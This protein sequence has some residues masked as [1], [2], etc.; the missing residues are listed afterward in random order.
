MKK[1]LG[2]AV[3]LGLVAGMASSALAEDILSIGGDARWRGVYMNNTT[4]SDDATA[5]KVQH[6][7]Q[8]YRLNADIKINDDVKVSTR[9]VLADNEFGNDNDLA[10]EIDRAHM[11]IDMFGGT[12]LIGRQDASWGNKFYS[13]GNQVDRLKAVYKSGDLTYGGYL[14]KTSEGDD[15]FGDGDQDS[16][17]A[18]IVGQAGSTK[19]GVLPTYL[20]NDTHVAGGGSED[21]YLIDAFFTTKAGA[22]TIMGELLYKGGDAGDNPSGDD[23]YGGFV[24]GAMGMNALTVKG[25]VAYYDGNMG[26]TGPARDCDNDFAPTLLIGTCQETAVYNFGETTGTTDDATYL[27]A[28]GADF[29]VNDKLTLGALLG[30]LMASEEGG[31]TNDQDATLLEVDLTARYA[32][33]QNASY[34]IGVAY[35]Q[36]D[37]VAGLGDHTSDDDWIVIGNGIDVKW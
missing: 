19:W 22:A 35:A 13:W 30:Y 9:I 37:E 28:A 21:G 12:Y 25:L 26:D 27:V 3:A 15:A 29:Q 16:Y 32:L 14:Q 17:A 7:D 23:Y 10:H 8:R 36:V 1:A 11:T 31:L 5:D 20:Y 2:F 34:H 6:M 24:G 4:D 18:F 33:A